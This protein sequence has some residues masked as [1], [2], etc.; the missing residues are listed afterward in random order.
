LGSG[1]NLS[2]SL[3]DIRR[4]EENKYIDKGLQLAEDI[5]IRYNKDG[6]PIGEGLFPL[7]A[8]SVIDGMQV[9]SF[10]SIN[11]F[12]LLPLAL[13][14][15]KNGSA[16]SLNKALY[17]YDWFN[18]QGWADGSGMGTLCL[19]KLRS[20]GYFHSFYLLKDKLS[21]QQLQRE[22][23]TMKWLTLFGMCYDKPTHTGEVA[24]NLRALAIPK[25]IYALS[26]TGEI[27]RQAALQAY[28][29]Y[30]DNALNF[31]P[32]FFGTIKSDYSGY[33]H[34]GA[35][36]SAYYPHAL[37]A[38]SLAAYLLHDTPFALS[39]N[40]L[41]NLKQALLTFQFFSANL[42]VPQA[43]TGRFPEKQEILH[44]ILPAF[45][46]TA[47]S[48]EKEDKDLIAAYKYIL[49]NNPVK[50][51]E[52]VADVN[53][54]LSYTS[55]L[56]ETELMVI[57][58]ENDVQKKTPKTG[59]L[60]MP[61]SGL[62]VVKNEEYHFNIKGYS[63]YIWDFESSSNENLYGRYNSYGQIEYFNLSHGL[64]SYNS[65]FDFSYFPGTTVKAMPSEM[66][67]AKKNGKML[68][69]NFSDETFL[70]GI[71]ISEKMAMFSVK[72]HDIKFD[73]SFRANKSVFIFDDVLLCLGS[74]IRN[75]DK[76]YPTVTTLF[77]IPKGQAKVADSSTVLTDHAGLLYIVKGDKPQVVD[78]GNFTVA[79]LNHSFSPN[80][81]QYHYYIL[82][83][84]NNQM[85]ELLL[86]LNT[87]IDVIQQ[88]GKAHIVHHKSLGVTYA[89]IF[90]EQQELNTTLV[91]KVNIPL[92]FILETKENG[93]YVLSLCEPDMRRVSVA[94]MDQLTE[95]DVLQEERPF[96]TEFILLGTHAVEGK[97]GEVSVRYE[98]GNTIVDIST[99]RGEN[100]SF[101]IRKK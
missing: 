56:G 86:S 38:G 17:I 83:E 59:S 36:N 67:I 101:T 100:Y 66:L 12:V 88:D 22:L 47:L 30:M 64:G 60:F 8:P 15:C 72:L 85:K 40:S 87:P 34:R 9:R 89:A 32:G 26:L 1:E 45:V 91:K 80:N 43:T 82:P 4:R 76:D 6:T 50:V 53:S 74:D 93:E 29:D 61:Y 70:S 79:Y 92:S 71:G 3:I 73:T 16:E 21:E 11:K 18:D 42:S 14:Y 81:G 99:I 98:E 19:E 90:D 20:S 23:K 46:Y 94:S 28:A 25:L 5:Q 27:E 75:E 48:F 51:N 63:K 65:S 41:N 54:D 13:D 58:L 7:Y 96:S 33:H 35:Y 69:R 52:F 55:S 49:Q 10:P 95:E 62:L 97:K 77:Q 68:H 78:K 39:E 57:G 24:D 44:E 84:K 2:H 31:G 37:Y